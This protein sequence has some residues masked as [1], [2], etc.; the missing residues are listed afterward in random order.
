[1]TT[2]DLVDFTNFEQTMPAQPDT[3]IKKAKPQN[4]EPQPNLK[5]LSLTDPQAYKKYV[6]EL[7]S[8]LHKQ[9]EYPIQPIQLNNQMTNFKPP[10]PVQTFQLYNFCVQ[11]QVNELQNL[12][13]KF[14]NL[15]L[16]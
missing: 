16:D 13:D 3:S 4:I 5:Q 12:I 15:K 10:Q 8:K 7:F 2:F 11:D 1:M 6:D 9:P 14:K